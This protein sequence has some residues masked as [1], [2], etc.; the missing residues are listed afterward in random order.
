MAREHIQFITGRLAEHALRTLLDR[1]AHES[2][3]E[4]SIEVLPITVAALM[5]PAW[6][7]KHMTVS[8]QA[9]QIMVPG[10]CLGELTVL[11][12]A[13]KL[14]VVRGPRDLHELPAFLGRRELPRDYGAHDIQ[15]VAEINHAPRWPPEEMVRE[16]KRLAAAGADLIDVG[17]EPGETWTGVGDCVRALR[18]AGLRVSIDSFNSDEITLAVRAGAELVLSVNDSNCDAAVDWGVEVVVIPDE[19][20][21]LRGLEG[22]IERLAVAG[23]KY[24]IDPILEPIGCGFAASLGRYLDIRRRYP[25]AEIMMGIGNLTELSEADSAPINLLLLGFCQEIGVRSVLTTQVINWARTSIQ[26]CDLARRMV[27][28]AVRHGIPPKHVEKNYVLL[29]DSKLYERG[30]EELERLS[31]QVRDRNFRVFAE[32]EELHVLSAGIYMADSDPFR[33]FARLL[34][35]LPKGMDASHAFYL[36]YELCKAKTALGLGKQYEQDE[37]LDWGFLTEAEPHHR[38]Q[39]QPPSPSA[40]S[41]SAP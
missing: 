15:I 6:I 30:G 7:A 9:T 5:T 40:D 1:L 22:T 39:R 35:E 27:Y 38:L 8:A 17:C 29:R 41:E 4:F 23:V 34:T 21:T 13:A 14:P 25:E 33:L 19:I 36:G 26:E 12:A 24:R 32:R 20:R 28:F 18:D 37:S 31:R 11:E 2:D 3:F 16:A 10:Y